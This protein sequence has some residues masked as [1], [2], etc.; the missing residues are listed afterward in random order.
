MRQQRE[1]AR[2]GWSKDR[3]GTD[4]GALEGLVN[5][6]APAGSNVFEFDERGI[7]VA[8]MAH[9]TVD[10]PI[11][12]EMVDDLRRVEPGPVHP[13]RLDV[14]RFHHLD[15]TRGVVAVRMRQHDMLDPVRSIPRT[16]LLDQAGRGVG[17]AA[18]DH[19]DREAIG[20]RAI[21]EGNRIATAGLG[22]DREKIDFVS[23]SKKGV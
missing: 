12:V 10:G 5:R 4:P 14:K 16:H 13:K 15:E 7:L 6:D 19:M 18:V 9:Q 8:Q 2:A 1:V 3:E 20:A 23:H 11:P 22:P 17:I 21:P